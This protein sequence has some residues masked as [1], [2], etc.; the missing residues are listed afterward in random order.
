VENIGQLTA[1]ESSNGSPVASNN[2]ISVDVHG[3]HI[4]VD[5]G[6]DSED[7]EIL[8]EKVSKSNKGKTLK[9][10]IKLWFILVFICHFVQQNDLI[11]F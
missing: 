8:D 6:D 3:S 7:L 4:S 10:F 5:A 9:P 2:S 1:N 11:S